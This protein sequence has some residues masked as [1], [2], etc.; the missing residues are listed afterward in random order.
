MLPEYKY[1]EGTHILYCGN[2][3]LLQLIPLIIDT[4][5]IM[6]NK[7]VYFHVIGMGPMTDYLVDNIKNSGLEDNIIYHGPIIAKNAAAYFKDADALYQDIARRQGSNRDVSLRPDQGSY[8]LSSQV[9]YQPG[10]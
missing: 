1:G 6:D 4:M 7:N 9:I 10:C 5:K 2:L 8:H 3:G